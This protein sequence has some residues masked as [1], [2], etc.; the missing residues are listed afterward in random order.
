MVLRALS[1][2]SS[3]VLATSSK[4]FALHCSS[5]VLPTTRRF[6]RCFLNGI[7][8][9][10]TFSSLAV[11][12]GSSMC[13]DV[14]TLHRN[15]R[16]GDAVPVGT[17]M[18]HHEVDI[19]ELHRCAMLQDPK[20]TSYIDPATGF[21]VFTEKA[22]LQRGTCCGNSCRHCPYGWSNVTA[23]TGN[24]R[25]LSTTVIA[26]GDRAAAK[27]RLDEIEKAHSQY[28]LQKQ[29]NL[30]RTKQEYEAMPNRN[31]SPNS[32]FQDE[33]VLIQAAPAPKRRGGV[34]GGRY[35]NKNVPYTG[36]GDG[37]TS[38][39]LTGERIS[40]H[41]LV[42]EAMGTVDE[43][44]SVVGLVYAFYRQERGKATD[45][46]NLSS[47]AI[48]LED[49]LLQIM[50]RLFDIGTHIA[51]PSRRP[52]SRAQ[53][54]PLSGSP[55]ES[56]SDSDVDEADG[57]PAGSFTPD[58]IGNGFSAEHVTALEDWIDLLTDTLPELRSFILPTGTVLSAQCHVARTVCR[59]TE[60]VVTPLVVDFQQ[61]DP[62]VLQYLNRLS[63]F[64]F[65]AARYVNATSPSA[66]DVAK[67]EESG[68][69]STVANEILYRKPSK[70]ATQ[71]VLSRKGDK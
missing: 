22:H 10:S 19:E 58:G 21:M 27:A 29:N 13:N 51:K 12:C 69:E 14:A 64:F 71:R 38:Q 49:W 70:T 39:L 36:T 28:L 62:H 24:R 5:V 1:R 63:D 2:S 52:T 44:C 17:T 50:S 35:T 65:A 3:L 57:D 48:D 30:A 41:S 45:A 31:Q 32:V 26:S 59:R 56:S 66:G 67:D 61:T 53:K 46:Q 42:F 8:D 6:R 54:G 68:Q 55:D 43:L 34:H 47:S 60:R 23:P 11:A 15:V 7:G 37:G 40:K 4:R 16:I 25:P 18:D 20:G 9:L 33:Q